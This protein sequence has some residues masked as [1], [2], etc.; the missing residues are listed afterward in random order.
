MR[1]RLEGPFRRWECSRW[2]IA[3]LCGVRS[4]G[5]WEP[6]ALHDDA[7]EATTEVYAAELAAGGDGERVWLLGKIRTRAALERA[8]EELKRHAIDERNSLVAAAD[9]VA[10]V[11]QEE[12]WAAPVPDPRRSV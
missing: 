3:W 9:A 8:L 5:W 7:G 4:P 10:R 6:E 2:R 12:G 1:W 11:S